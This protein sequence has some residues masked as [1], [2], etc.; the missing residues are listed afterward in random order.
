M[1]I[2]GRG[3]DVTKERLFS[4]CVDESVFDT[5]SRIPSFGLMLFTPYPQPFLKEVRRNP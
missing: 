5:V 1:P 4:G 3:N 2:G